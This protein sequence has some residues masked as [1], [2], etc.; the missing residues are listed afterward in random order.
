[1]IHLSLDDHPKQKLILLNAI[2]IVPMAKQ[3]NNKYKAN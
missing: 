2:E 3:N 1:M